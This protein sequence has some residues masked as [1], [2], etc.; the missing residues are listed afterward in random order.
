MKSLIEKLVLFCTL[1]FSLTA[2]CFIPIKKANKASF[3][4]F[5]SQFFTWALG[6]IVVE[7]KW[8]E[9]PVRE[10]SKTNETSL[11]FEY[12]VLPITT[13]FF[14]LCYPR[15]KPLKIRVLYYITIISFFTFI[16]YLLE[17]YTMVI[18]YHGW[19]WYW[20]WISLCCLLYLLMLIYN[21]FFKIK[22]S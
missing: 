7:L 6:L 17:K 8:L 4:F 2:L 5:L 21:W 3:I 20:T 10:F 16:E 22:L 9:Y 14:I 1:V 12:A 13:I 19:Q 18:E 11:L 15:K